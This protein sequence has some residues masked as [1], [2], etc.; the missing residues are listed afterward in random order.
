V[1]GGQVHHVHP[2]VEALGRGAGAHPVGA[3]R[4][5]QEPQERLFR[6]E[7]DAARIEAAQGR[8]EAGEAER[9]AEA[10]LGQDEDRPPPERAAV[11]FGGIHLAGLELAREPAGSVVAEALGVAPGGELREGELDAHLGEIGKSADALLEK[12]DPLLVAPKRAE[13]LAGH[14]GV[15]G[16]A[17]RLA[18]EVAAQGQAA[19][20]LAQVVE[21][22]GEVVADALVAGIE[23]EGALLRAPGLVVAALGAEQRAEIGPDPGI[24]R[25]AREVGRVERQGLGP[26]SGA[27]GGDGPLAQGGGRLVEGQRPGRHS[28]AFSRRFTGCTSRSGRRA[29]AASKSEKVWLT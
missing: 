22:V 18:H 11:P 20:V 10:L 9:V 19:L 29:S 28:A 5:G 2:D 25:L 4:A 13:R 21:D 23:R 17:R 14:G 26:P 15:L 12:G 3:L 7:R 16:I 6:K 24:P 8:Q 27:V 1:E